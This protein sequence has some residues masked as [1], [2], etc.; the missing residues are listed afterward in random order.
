MDSVS[1]T[2]SINADDMLDDIY[3]LD[4]SPVK[5]PNIEPVPGF[6]VSCDKKP[7]RIIPGVHQVFGDIM[8]DTTIRD[9]KNHLQGRIA[10]DL[11]VSG[12]EGLNVA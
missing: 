10:F 12:I 8:E 3:Q 11:V 9:I 7:F 5:K 4:L 1:A 2:D 6:C